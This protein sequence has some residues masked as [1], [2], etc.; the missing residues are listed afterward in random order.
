MS[1][2]W[3]DD[4]LDRMTQS[5][6]SQTRNLSFKILDNRDKVIKSVTG[7]D[8]LNQEILIFPIE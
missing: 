8:K 1:E 6:N 7:L 5:N 2:A 4:V 3:I